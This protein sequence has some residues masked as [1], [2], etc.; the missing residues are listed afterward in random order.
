VVVDRE[1]KD[2]S[3][4]LT[5]ERINAIVE[6]IKKRVAHEVAK[7]SRSEI[8]AMADRATK[9][10]QAQLSPLVDIARHDIETEQRAELERLQA[11]AA[12]NPNIRAEE[13]DYREHFADQL[14]SHVE[15]TQLK[16]DAVRVG[17]AT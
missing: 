11:L 8:N 4:V 1:C 13:I 7:H 15:H 16:L 5:Q 14:L 12:V 2:L 9:I 3:S 6:P 10:A 17:L